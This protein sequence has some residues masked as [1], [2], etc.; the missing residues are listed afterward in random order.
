MVYTDEA[1]A[2]NGLAPQYGHEAVNHGVGEYVRG[3]A[4]TNGIE[5]FWSMLKRSYVGAY[6]KISAKHLD[7]Y[8]KEFASRHNVR[9]QD[10]IDQ[11]SAAV[12]GMVGQRLLYQDLIAE[13]GLNNGARAG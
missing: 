6:H 1:K 2:H 12:V 4:H 3:M 8:V 10:T 13:N 11:M 9:E 7:R 5:A